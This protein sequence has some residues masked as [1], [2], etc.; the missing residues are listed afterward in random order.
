[1]AVTEDVLKQHPFFES[2]DHWY[3]EQ[4]SR[5]ADVVHY[6]KGQFIFREGEEADH[7]YLILKGKVN[8]GLFGK[9]E[10]IVIQPLEEGEIL[11]WSWLV[12]PYRWRFDAYVTE[13][14]EVISLNGKYL[15]SKC[16]E[17]HHLG[18]SLIKQLTG[19]FWQRLQNIRQKLIERSQSS[20]AK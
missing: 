9:A 16:E 4:L 12:E 19:I 2:L 3:L 7:F 8:V 10:D 11:G 13:D 20:S 5:Y 1:M 6:K 15:R 14:V 17:D 18:Y